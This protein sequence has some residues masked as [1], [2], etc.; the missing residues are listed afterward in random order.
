ME[1]MRRLSDGRWVGLLGIGWFV[2]FI[3]GAAVLQGEPPPAGAPVAQ[4]RDFFH[5]AGRRYLVGD[6]VAG[7]AFM[8]L[9][10]PFGVLLPRAL[11]TVNRPAPWWSQLPAAGVVALVTVG[12]VATSFLD[13][14][15]MARGGARLDDST[16]AALLYANSAGI[17]LIGLPAAVFAGSAA[18]LV[19]HAAG[20]RT[21]AALGWAAAGLLVAG[22]AFPVAGDAHGPLW[23]VRF[24]SFLALAAFVLATSGYLLTRGPRAVTAQHASRDPVQ[25]R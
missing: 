15:A 19:R 17:A 5:A 18:T 4:V 9:L 8:L 11:S 1:P 22:A 20:P 25:F 7:C 14:V 24:V 10:L 16:V 13:A 6:F 3:V 12:G 2:L 23:T 21:I